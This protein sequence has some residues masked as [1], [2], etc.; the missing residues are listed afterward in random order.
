VGFAKEPVDD[1]DVFLYH[2][3]T[4]RT[5]HAR[6]RASRPDCDDVLL[7]NRRGEVTESTVANVVAIL[8]GQH[9]TPPVECGLLAG[10]Y[11][12]RLLAEG[13]IREAVLTREDLLRAESVY[14]INSVRKRIPVELIDPA[15]DPPR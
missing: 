3:T 2:K 12:A 5:V 9:L 15:P 4:H 8:A 11:R 13:R 10:T 7:W 6:A 14:L 1:S